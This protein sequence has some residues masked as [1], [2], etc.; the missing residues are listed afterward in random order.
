MG[1]PPEADCEV[2][3][4]PL[5]SGRACAGRP[6]ARGSLR[7]TFPKTGCNSTGC[8]GFDPYV[9]GHA[10][11]A[12]LVDHLLSLPDEPVLNS[13]NSNVGGIST[14]RNLAASSD[15]NKTP[16]LD[17]TGPWSRKLWRIIDAPSPKTTTSSFTNCCLV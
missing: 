13:P 7:G 11:A 2:E 6:D 17:V 14:L 1:N 15:R 10:D 5:D 8:A 3:C 16:V 12:S 4:G 9:N